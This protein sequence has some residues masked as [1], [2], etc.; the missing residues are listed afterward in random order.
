MESYSDNDSEASTATTARR[1][2]ELQGDEPQ[3]D[4]QDEEQNAEQDAEQNEELVG[5]N[6]IHEDAPGGSQEQVDA[7][8]RTIGSVK[9]RIPQDRVVDVY[10][11]QVWQEYQKGNLIV[12]QEDLEYFRQAHPIAKALAER[13]SN[14]FGPQT[15]AMIAASQGT[16]SWID[17]SEV[18]TPR[19]HEG[20]E[21]PISIRR[22]QPVNESPISIQRR[23]EEVES[24]ISIQR[25]RTAPEQSLK[26]LL[27]V[28][29]Q[30]QRGL[31]PKKCCIP[32][33][34]V[35]LY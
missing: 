15:Q 19:R 6:E 27:L 8:A 26:R 22:Q 20:I 9:P 31:T 18:I 5:I 17:P 24:P 12:T 30:D 14:P 2:W 29:L 1:A 3:D 35:P 28:V 10:W 34:S 4:E 21:S 11:Q 33:L 23:N 25:Q 13:D 7:V 16:S 32:A